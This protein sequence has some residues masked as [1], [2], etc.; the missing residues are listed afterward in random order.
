MGDLRSKLAAALENCSGKESIL[1]MSSWSLLIADADEN[2]PVADLVGPLFIPAL[3]TLP[4]LND[5]F[6]PSLELIQ[7]HLRLVVQKIIEGVLEESVVDS[8][9]PAMKNLLALETYLK[10]EEKIVCRIVVE[11]LVDRLLAVVSAYGKFTGSKTKAHILGFNKA[12]VTW[13][14]YKLPLDRKSTFHIDI[15]RHCL[16]GISPCIMAHRELREEKHTEAMDE[17]K[18][19]LNEFINIAGG[20]RDR[21]SWK[22]QITNDLS[23]EQVLDIAFTPKTGLVNGPGNKVMSI[24]LALG[25][26]FGESQSSTHI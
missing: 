26:A 10:T 25:Q 19:N 18:M 13:L 9:R 17:L 23:L 16:S 7:E 11:G 8:L 4:E 24:K 2:S 12:M 5:T 6:G 15:L 14:Q 1:N 21:S 20:S 3:D 22:E